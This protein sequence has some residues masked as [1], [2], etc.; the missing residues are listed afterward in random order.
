MLA[1]AAR[2]WYNVRMAHQ[3]SKRF[4]WTKTPNGYV[5]EISDLN[6]DADFRSFGYLHLPPGTTRVHFQEFKE[7][8][9]SENE[10]THWGWTAPSGVKYTIFND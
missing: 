9:N 7:Q 8:R 5:T 1:F 10:L 4:L 6:A 3:Y 2:L